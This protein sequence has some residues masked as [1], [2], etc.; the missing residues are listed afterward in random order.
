MG[1]DSDNEILFYGAH[2]L[3]TGINLSF[4]GGITYYDRVNNKLMVNIQQL[5]TLS[6]M[7]AFGHRHAL[8]CS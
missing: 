3:L 2:L 1:R 7:I 6:R 8:T 4:H 5:M